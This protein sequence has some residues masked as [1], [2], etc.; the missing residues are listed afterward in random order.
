MN[1]FETLKSVSGNSPNQNGHS[2]LFLWFVR[3]LP[4]GRPWPDDEVNI[5][6]YSKRYEAILDH[7]A[8]LS[9]FPESAS[10]ED[11]RAHRERFS[12]FMADW[13]SLPREF[14]ENLLPLSLNWFADTLIS[15]IEIL[16]HPKW[17]ELA[18]DPKAFN[19]QL[20]KLLAD[21]KSVMKVVYGVPA[22]G[23]R[24]TTVVIAS[25]GHFDSGIRD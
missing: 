3:N 20:N 8:E 2:L 14:A 17:S 21:L 13:E 23:C 9:D 12:R 16:A 19:I 4:T 25:F 24:G 10:V 7:L 15:T 22:T 11:K 6:G 5:S 18:R 1:D